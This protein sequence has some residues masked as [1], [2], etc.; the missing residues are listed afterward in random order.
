MA[1]RIRRRPLRA[2]LTAFVIA[3]VAVPVAGAARP[4]AVPAPAPAVLAPLGDADP[5]ALGERYAAVRADIRAAERTAAGHGDRRRAAVLRGLAG[6]G[7]TFLSFDG[8]DGGRTAEVIGDLAGAER[9]AVLVPGADTSLDTYARF[10]EG[11]VAL[12]RELPA[13]SVVVAWL[14]YRTPATVSTETLTADRAERAA[15]ALRGF[16]RE[17]SGALPSA[18]VSVLCHSYGSVVCAEAAPGLPAAHLVLYGSPGTGADHRDRLRTGATVWAGRGTGDWIAAVPHTRVRLPFTTVGFGTDPVSDAFG[19]Q[20]FDA[21]TAGHADY[22][23]P[24]SLSLTNIARIVSDRASP[25]R[26]A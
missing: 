13:R 4:G 11:A 25:H 18:R 21:G 12:R 10:H 8:R 5:A 1:P 23:R 26:D 19:A 24:R 22:L 17:L 14:G 15:P 6:S 3:S 20:V 9:V 16:V 7:R 2:L